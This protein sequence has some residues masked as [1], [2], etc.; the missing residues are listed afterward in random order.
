[1]IF[2]LNREPALVAGGRYGG[3]TIKAAAQQSIGV[4]ARGG[5]MAPTAEPRW[6]LQKP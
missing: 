3:L 6:V 1:M 2:A 4:N 5:D